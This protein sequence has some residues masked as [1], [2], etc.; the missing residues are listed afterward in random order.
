MATGSSEGHTTNQAGPQKWA[1]DE[2]DWPTFKFEFLNW[3]RRHAPELPRLLNSASE[4]EAIF[5]AD[6]TEAATVLAGKVMTD[7]SLRT[8]ERAQRALMAISEA[9]N[10][11]EGWKILTHMGE[12]GGGIK[13]AGLLRQ[14]L[15]YDFSGDY[16]DRLNL[17]EQL[18]RVYNKRGTDGATLD[19]EVLVATIVEGSTG[20]LRKQLV[21]HHNDF[22]TYEKILKYIREYFDCSRAFVLPNTTRKAARGTSAPME[23]DAMGKGKNGKGK[24]KGKSEKGSKGQDKGGKS[25]SKGKGGKGGK[26]SSSSG[27]QTSGGNAGGDQVKF[28]GYCG[29]CGKWGHKQSD[30]W[31]AI[32]G[33]KSG[34]PPSTVSNAALEGNAA[35]SSSSASA[36]QNCLMMEVDSSTPQQQPSQQRTESSGWMMGLQLGDLLCAGMEARDG[37]Y[38]GLVDSGSAVTAAGWD[39]GS[40]FDTVV[41]QH[42]PQLSSVSGQP[43]THYGHRKVACTIDT[44]HGPQAACLSTEIADVNKVVI[45]VSALQDHML[46]T[47]FPPGGE[48]GYQLISPNGSITNLD[49]PCLVR[50]NTT[51]PLERHNGVFWMKL[52]VSDSVPVQQ[53]LVIAPVD[54]NEDLFDDMMQE[55]NQDEE[56]QEPQEL[57]QAVDLEVDEAQVQ[58]PSVPREPSFQDRINHDLTG[59]AKYAG[60]CPHCV[61]GRGSEAAHHRVQDNSEVPKLFLDYGFLSQGANQILEAQAA[62][63][64]RV[65]ITYAVLVDQRSGAVNATVVQ[66]KGGGDDYANARMAAWIQRLGYARVCLTTDNENSVKAFAK[67][68]KSKCACDV[69]V[70]TRIKGS[71]A[72]LASGETSIQLVAGAVRSLCSDLQERAGKPVPLESHL[73]K[74]IVP[75]AGFCRTRFAVGS[76]GTTPYQRL[77]GAPYSGL[78]VSFG[79]EVMVKVYDSDNKF[80]SKWRRGCWVG[81]SELN[82]ASFIA[83]TAGVI[84]GRT[85]H[86]LPDKPF[87]AVALFAMPGVPWD[88]SL[89]ATVAAPPRPLPPAVVAAPVRAAEAVPADG[90]EAG[91]VSVTDDDSSSSEPAAQNPAPAAAAV[92]AAGSTTPV[93]GDVQVGGSPLLGSPLASGSETP[94]A[95]TRP[96]EAPLS[97]SRWKKI[98]TS[99]WSLLSPNIPPMPVIGADVQMAT[100]T[101]RRVNHADSDVMCVTCEDLVLNSVDLAEAEELVDWQAQEDQQWLWD[102]PQLQ[103]EVG[104]TEEELWEARSVEVQNLTD[105]KAFQWVALDTAVDGKWIKSRWEEGRKDTGLYRSR[106]VL[107]E[108]ATVKVE[109]DFFSATPD[110]QEIELVHLQALLEGQEVRYLDFTRAFLHAPEFEKVYTPPPVGWER[111][112]WCWQLLRKINGRRDG[113]QTFT[114]WLS[115]QL[116]QQGWRRSDLN[117]CSFMRCIEG[118]TCTLTTHV[119]DVVLVGGSNTLDQ[120]MRELNEF[121]LCKEVG[122]LP[123]E[124]K[125]GWIPFLGRDRMRDG[126]KLYTR[127]K[128][129]FILKAA[130]L[131]GLRG[132]KPVEAPTSADLYHKESD[133]V[134]DDERKSVIRQVVGVLHYVMNDFKIAQFALRGLAVEVDK[135]TEATWLRVKHL[136]RYLLGCAQHVQTMQPDR[137]K[138]CIQAWSDSDWA[139][140][141]SSRKSVDCVVIKLYGCTIHSSSRGQQAT[142]LS[143]AEAELGGAHRAALYAVSIQNSWLEMFSACLNIEIY[144]DSSAG[145]IMGTRRGKGRVR[146]LEVK[147]LY[148]QRLVNSGRVNLNKC[149]GDDNV[150]DVG[151]KPIE[152]RKIARFMEQ[153]NIEVLGAADSSRQ[154]VIGAWGPAGVWQAIATLLAAG[155]FGRTDGQELDSPGA[156]ASSS[157]SFFWA[158]LL[159]ALLLAAFAGFF[160]GRWSSCSRRSLKAPVLM[161]AST[162]AALDLTV[163][164]AAAAAE[165]TPSTPAASTK[166]YT[167]PHG[168]KYHFDRSCRGLVKASKVCGPYSRCLVCTKAE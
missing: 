79:E 84:S 125:S 122:R 138:P 103:F 97:P 162:S 50:G 39:F 114:E 63:P 47:W 41:P 150:A 91:S 29:A 146:H 22:D 30:C 101:V 142:A 32:S 120:I 59:H 74:W 167:T 18:V 44:D 135:A 95:V 49:G 108:F 33:G 140:E 37:V 93:A 110:N 119:D 48:A 157:I 73:M 72:S 34:R 152:R 55:F 127:P 10:G 158:F 148:L 133:T 88:R 35:A 24:A 14:L 78:M 52:T 19:E 161:D 132:A 81:K 141:R 136:V 58:Q 102:E 147:Q 67:R 71:S 96:A 20:D 31:W 100:L 61:A 131:L 69:M 126:D 45:S 99:Q 28:A 6:M 43:I 130:E 112:G 168:E 4:A 154:Q 82:D 21:A 145:K 13:R 17:F 98:R 62:Q 75:F 60:W 25:S 139:G 86:R 38:Y 149:R 151:T 156:S 123:A 83:T 113:T 36:G 16:L 27:Q 143:S 5:L 105:F 111:P 118:A 144:M 65:S 106:W 40:H 94:R 42:P 57:D 12:G 15:K 116:Q 26:T 80:K 159:V 163:T 1:G 7:L 92:P 124:G 87:D 165:A 70:R 129:K 155:L 68:I 104:P 134:L 46:G 121:V 64:G 85:I 164:E 137:N 166:L 54:N 115:I 160:V 2:A 90:S 23:V 51:S 9:D 153:L 8:T 53:P 76:D 117:P 56:E 77:N 11:F 109:A 3:A 128:A 66:H 89:G 107:Q